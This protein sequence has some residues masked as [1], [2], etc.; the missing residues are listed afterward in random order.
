MKTT[1]LLRG[2]I[3]NISYFNICIILFIYSFKFIEINF[4]CQVLLFKI[5]SY[6]LY[7]TIHTVLS[8]LTIIRIN[9]DGSYHT[10]TDMI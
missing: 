3:I 6:I 7:F 2:K 1:V 4:I 5:L 9:H 10:S 8:S